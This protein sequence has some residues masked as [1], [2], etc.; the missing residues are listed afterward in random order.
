MYPFIKVNKKNQKLIFNIGVTVI[1]VLIFLYWLVSGLT[2]QANSAIISYNSIKISNDNTK[3]KVEH[4]NED[5]TV[6]LENGDKYKDDDIKEYIKVSNGIG[7]Y[8]VPEGYMT[9]EVSRK[10][11]LKLAS[12]FIILDVVVLIMFICLYIWKHK[13]WQLILETFGYCCV[14]FFSSIVL[15]FWCVEIYRSAF[16]ISWV[17][18]GKCLLYVLGIW[19]FWF[20]VSMRRR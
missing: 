16:P 4:I 19:L 7:T 17:L 11:A 2:L 5:N 9:V 3:V 6:F 20:L 15:R 10:D 13:K 14:S 18:M 1:C 8:Y 12:T